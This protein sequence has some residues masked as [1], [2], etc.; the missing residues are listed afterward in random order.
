MLVHRAKPFTSVKSH[1]K[2]FLSP[3]YIISGVIVDSGI[4]LCKN[5]T[6]VDSEAED[7]RWLNTRGSTLCCEGRCRDQE[8]PQH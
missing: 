1:I 2:R 4:L 3:T 7:R 5:T 8:Q 6:L